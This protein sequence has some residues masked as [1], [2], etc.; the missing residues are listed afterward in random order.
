M[1]VGVLGINVGVETGVAVEGVGVAVVSA[2]AVGEIS[3]TGAGSA[4]HAPT[5]NK[6]N[7]IKA[8]VMVLVFNGTPILN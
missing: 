5:A 7:P 3:V 2:V 4:E 8:T 1:A 6:A